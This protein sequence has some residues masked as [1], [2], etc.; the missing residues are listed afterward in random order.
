MVCSSNAALLLN[1]SG[2]NFNDMNLK[3]IRLEDT[4]L[5][6]V[7]FIRANLNGLE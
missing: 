2:I 1:A 6:G 4:D 3:D 5:S 7:N